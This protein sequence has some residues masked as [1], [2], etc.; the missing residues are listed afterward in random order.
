MRKIA[1]LVFALTFLLTACEGD[2]GPPG[3]PGQNGVIIV[4]QSFERTTDLVAPNYEATFEI[5]LDIELLETDMV[6]VYHLVGI[7]IDGLDIWRLLPDTVYTNDGQ[8][9]Q[10]NF[11]HNFDLVTVFIEAPSTFDFNSLLDADIFDQTFRTVILPVDFVNSN[12][13]DVTNYSD[14]MEYIQ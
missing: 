6:L 5:P 14:V 13:L 10:Y 1:S 3:P 2:P 11:E 8:Q 9:F 12:N 7:D 4:G